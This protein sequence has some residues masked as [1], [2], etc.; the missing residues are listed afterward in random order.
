MSMGHGGTAPADTAPPGA[1]GQVPLRWLATLREVVGPTLVRTENGQLTGYVMFNVGEAGEE[2]VMADALAA[3]GRYPVPPGLR[4]EPAGRYLDKLEADRRLAF[5]VPIVIAINLLLL[6]LAFRR[7]GLTLAIFAAIPIAF[8]G[9]F[10]GLWLY[11]ILTFGEPIHLTTAVWVGFIALFG[12][13]V[14]DGAVM[15]TYLVQRFKDRS[16]TTVAEIR[17][18]VVDAGLRRIR[19]CLMTTATTIVSLIP[20]LWSSGRGADVMKPMALPLLGGL[21]VSLVTL[22]TVPAMFSWLEERRLGEIR[23][24]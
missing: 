5:I 18:A 8:A 17:Q 13:S 21:M 6:H 3:V 22:F 2:R 7:V 9:G 14:D 1:G 16:F 20:V 19:P 11:P 10:I 24:G 4:I 12:I 15:G 23:E